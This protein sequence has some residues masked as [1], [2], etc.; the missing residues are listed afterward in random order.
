MSGI[1]N[2]I[3]EAVHSDKSHHGAPEG[4]YGP[5]NTRA[6][7]AADPRVDSDRDNSHT[8]GAG[9]TAGHGEFGSTGFGTGTAEG[10]HGPHNSRVANA[11]DPRVDSDRDNSR[12]MGTGGTTGTGT[13]GFGSTHHTAGA[14]SGNTGM[15]GTHGAPAGTYGPHGSRMANAADPRV[16]SD[17]DGRGAIGS[18]PGP[19][20][21]TAGPHK[22]DM[23]NKMD[24][25][26]DSD[27]DG[28]RA[29]GGNKTYQ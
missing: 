21:D 15:T 23:A 24:P 16:D 14:G 18:G 6:A 19:A 13:T 17:R 5:H 20:H 3:K 29:M 4:T 27:L 7:N 8:I 1:V 26:V 22:S 25:R 9:R 28:S 12:T 11:I 10:T 2:K